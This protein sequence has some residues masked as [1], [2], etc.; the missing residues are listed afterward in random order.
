MNKNEKA[1]RL[2]EI[3]EL[4]TENSKTY[5]MSDGTQQTV[6]TVDGSGVSTA[7]AGIMTLAVTEATPSTSMET[8]SWQNSVFTDSTEHTVGMTGT[9]GNLKTNRM[10]LTVNIPTL[11][12]NPRIKNAELVLKQ[13]SYAGSVTPAIGLYKITGDLET[14]TVDTLPLDYEIKKN[15]TNVEYH[16]DI[17]KLID[18][19]SHTPNSTQVNLAAKLIKEEEVHSITNIVVYGASS[20][21]NNPEIYVTYE[22]SYGSSSYYRTHNHNLGK[23]GAATVDLACGNLMF[24]ST[25]FAWNGN[26]MPIT[27]KRTYNSILSDKQYTADTSVGLRIADFSAMKLGLGWRL[28]LMQSM[29]PATVYHEDTKYDNGYIYTNELGNE[30]IFLPEKNKNGVPTGKFKSV[31]NENILYDPETTTLTIG[32]SYYKFTNGRLT[33]IK[34]FIKRDTNGN[35]VFNINTITYTNNRITKVTDGAE[36]DFIFG[37]NNNGYL[38]SVKAPNFSEVKYGYTSDGRLSSVIY[39]DNSIGQMT[40]NSNGKPRQIILLNSEKKKVFRTTYNYSGDRLLNFTVHGVENDV[41]VTGSTTSFE[42][43]SASNRTKVTVSEP[44]D[45]DEGETT[46]TELHTIYTFDDEGGIISEYTYSDSFDAIGINSDNTESHFPYSENIL[47]DHSFETLS[48]WNAMVDCVENMD[49]ESKSTEHTK[50]GRFSLK[51]VAKNVTVT[52]NGVYQSVANLTAGE[53]TFSAYTKVFETFIG[54]N[55]P[56]VYLRVINEDGVIITE[57]NHLIETNSIHNRIVLP[58]VLE[59]STNIQVQI[60]VNGA[61]I[62]YVS[63]P[64]LENGGFATEYNMMSNSNFEKDNDN[65]NFSDNSVVVSATDRFRG[66]KSLAITSEIEELHYAYQTIPVKTKASTKETFTLSGWAKA[67]NALP[68][69]YRYK[70]DDFPTFRIRAAIKYTDGTQEDHCAD[71]SP[72]TGDWQYASV[73]FAKNEIKVIGSIRIACDYSYNVGTAYFD[74][75]SL[76]CNDVEY[77]LDI[78]NFWGYNSF[79]DGQSETEEYEISDVKNYHRFEELTDDFGNV[80]TNTTFYNGEHGTIYSSN[81]YDSDGNN[82]IIETDARGNI[83]TY[84]ADENSSKNTLVT[85]RC[86]NKTTYE[87]DKTGKTT[88]ITTKT[89][90]DVE[91]ANIT[92]RY[93]NFDNMTQIVR[94]DGMKYVLGYNAFHQFKSVDVD[95]ID[96]SLIRYDYKNGNGRLKSVTYANGDYMKAMYNALGQMV[97]ETWYGKDENGNT[98]V[99]AKYKYVY[100]NNS[101]IVRTIDIISLKEYNYIYEDN[102]LVTATEY[103]ITIGNNEMVVSKTITNTVSYIYDVD[104]N[105]IRKIVQPVNDGKQTV[106][107]EYPENG[108]TVVKFEI[109]HPNDTYNLTVTSHSKSDSF[110]RKIFDELQHGLGVT[111]RHFSYHNGEVTEEHAEA[112]KYKSAP[113]TDL[114]K[115]IVISSS[116]QWEND[117][118]LSYEYDNEERITKIIDSLDGITEYSYDDLGQLLTETTDGTIVNSMTYDRYGNILSKN[119][120]IYVYDTTWKDQ[121]VSYDDQIIVYDVQGNPTSYLG[122][123]LE[124]EKGRQL[125]SYDNITYTYNANGIR[126]SKKVNN[127][128]HIYIIEG[129]KILR[130]KW[131]THILIPLYDNDENICGIKHNQFTYFFIKNLQGDV[132]ALIDPTG[133]V[134]VRYTYDAWGKY[135]IVYDNTIDNIGNINPFRYRGYYYDNETG[136]YYL[137]SRYYDPKT[138]RFINGDEAIYVFMNCS[139]LNHNLFEY[140]QNNPVSN[141]DYAGTWY[142]SLMQY[143]DTRVKPFDKWVTYNRYIKYLNIYNSYVQQ[144]NSNCMKLKRFS[145]YI[146]NQNNPPVN[147]LAFGVSKIKDVGCEIISI[148]NL[149]VAKKKEVYFPDV[150]SECYINGL[151]WLEGRFGMNPKHMYR[152]FDAHKINYKKTTSFN[153]WYE[154]LKDKK[155]GIISYWNKWHV[156]D[157]IHTVF[158]KYDRGHFSGYNI[159]TNQTEVEDFISL[160]EFKEFMDGPFIIGYT[161]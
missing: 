45:T 134:R 119:G 125:R 156:F 27:I 86:G 72:C 36:R 76:T 10:Y 28:N 123:N 25:D 9:T 94:G 40:Y 31:D 102:K 120:K 108:N 46:N 73:Q 96:T 75:I 144:Y 99:T 67:E 56:G 136:F 68:E 85:D 38:T 61:G 160:T 37:Y 2:Y 103:S 126:T 104:D 140:C 112:E 39:P 77:D 92:Y 42:Y 53:Y 111:T 23:F 22:S 63:N 3:S 90:S 141:V 5:A 158:V 60:L 87:Y 64:Q 161:F 143:Y 16:F 114:I 100:D 152:Y 131:D 95:S 105:I 43:S 81:T 142:Y 118:I 83:T 115:E 58:F 15:S 33:E 132:I 41:Y 70:V 4:R 11:P 34:Q 24:E 139:P 124:W 98:V 13:K 49:Y 122:H 50:N 153:K 14:G 44:A 71:F 69:R 147:N 146:Y 110:G 29:I 35:E 12:R 6:F 151:A 84:M 93:N 150:I 127:V 113:T 59:E 78:S 155:L 1:V 149:L 145:G 82:L 117:R 74:C 21:T 109:Q 57:S 106:Y 121:L 89:A 129:T 7:N 138:G 62:V 32:D 66:S 148:Y 79:F 154:R 54:E 30:S 133:K 80:I 17:T 97:M 51:L 137:Q 8:K 135:S 52:E 116:N 88:K 55:S 107:Y 101:N 48:S 20:T 18:E 65:W 130:E 128:E 19:T 91:L 47:R 157:G 26:R 159:Y